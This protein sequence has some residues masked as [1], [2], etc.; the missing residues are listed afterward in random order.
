MIGVVDIG[1]NTIRLSCY[2]IYDDSTFECVIH[3]KEVAGLAGYI[4][5]NGKMTDEGIERAIV[6]IESFKTVINHM[7]L[8]S[9]HFFA[10]AAIRN[11]VN[12]KKIVSTIQKRTRYEIHVLSGEEEAICD[13]VGVCGDDSVSK[14][15]VIDIGGGSTEIVSFD[16]KKIIKAKSFGIGSLNLYKGYVKN[17][18]PTKTEVTEIKKK[19]KRILVEEIS[20]SKLETAYGVGGSI[21][22]VLKIYNEEYRMSEDNREMELDKIKK[23]LKLYEDNKNCMVD[24][25]IKVAPERL[26]TLIPGLIILCTTAKHF[27]IKKIHVSKF[28]VR[29]GY[30]LRHILK[31]STI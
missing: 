15:I 14:G 17:I 25:I 19:V 16:N 13:F 7:E 6:A 20:G 22:A 29:E 5:E 30:L 2:E 12:C 18:I 10:T 3:K 23:L 21:R 31:K 26:H 8:E 24:R 11:T 9:I 27:N 28:G 4:D 1:S